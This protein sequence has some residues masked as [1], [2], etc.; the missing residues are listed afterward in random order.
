MIRVTKTHIG[1]LF[2]AAARM[3]TPGTTAFAGPPS[4]YN[5]GTLGGGTASYARGINSS[6][7]I[8]G[9]CLVP[10]SAGASD[11]AFLYSGTPGA[12]GAMSD[13]GFFSGETGQSLALAIDQSGQIAGKTGSYALTHAFLY[14]GTPGQGGV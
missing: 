7:Q 3:A 14:S 10:S 6:G 8:V 13:L 4:I 5:L 2:I 9:Y 1:A 12:G 11:H